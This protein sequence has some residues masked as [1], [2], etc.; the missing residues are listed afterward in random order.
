MAAEAAVRMAVFWT[1]WFSTCGRDAQCGEEGEQEGEE[2]G[3]EIAVFDVDDAVDAES[4]DAEEKWNEPE[5]VGRGSPGGV[6][7]CSEEEEN[8]E[9]S[10]GFGVIAH[11]AEDAHDALADDD[12]LEARIHVG[13]D[14]LVEE[15]RV[16]PVGIGAVGEFCS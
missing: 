16:E 10:I 15:G 12:D 9:E 3:A 6:E 14:V 13:L 2:G 4:G 7:A 1:A 8:G 5:G 11:V